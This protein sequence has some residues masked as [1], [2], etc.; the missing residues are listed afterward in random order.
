[1]GNFGLT[2]ELWTDLL[3]LQQMNMDYLELASSL[4]DPLDYKK[5]LLDELFKWKVITK[6]RNYLD[7]S[8]N[9]EVI[10][11]KP[12]YRFV[13]K[14]ILA[15]EPLCFEGI[16]HPLTAKYLDYCKVCPFYWLTG[17]DCHRQGSLKEQ[18]CRPLSDG[19][20]IFKPFF[21][22]KLI[23][24]IKLESPIEK[25]EVLRNDDKAAEFASGRYTG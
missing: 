4:V 19:R 5:V 21:M 23:V 15:D 25:I 7:S 8:G 13:L 9:V 10:Q 2:K 20:G 18:V 17:L 6:W 16:F 11:T 3:K 1:M 12:S 22:A 24:K 14:E